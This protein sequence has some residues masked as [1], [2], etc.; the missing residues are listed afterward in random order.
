MKTR[1]ISLQSRIF[2]L[3]IV[4]VF[5][6]V[7]VKTYLENRYFKNYILNSGAEKV[8]YVAKLTAN[9]S[10]IIE[11]FELSDPSTIIQP[12]AEK[13]REITNTSF[14]VVMNMDSIRYSHPNIKNIGRY[15]VGGDEGKAKSGETYVSQARGTLGISQ[16]AFVPIYNKKNIQIGIVSVGLLITALEE[17]NILIKKILLI[18]ALISI[19]I[20]LLGGIFLANNIKKNIFGLEPYQI[21]TLLEERDAIIS[22]IKEGIIAVDKDCRI[23]LINNNA[24]VLIGVD[25]VPP[26]SIITDIFPE[27]KLPFVIKSKKEILQNSRFINGNHLLVNNIPMI[28]K[29]K[30]IGAVSS[31][32][33]ISEVLNLT[34]ELKETRAYTDALRA[35][36]HEYLNRLNVMSGLLQLKKYREATD[37]IVSTVSDQQNISD[38]LRK[39]IKTPSI[40]G[41]LIAKINRANEQHIKLTIN[42]DSYLPKI[43]KKYSEMLV[44]II[45]NI[46]ENSIESLNRA[47]RENKEI[48]IIFIDSENSIEIRI[49]DNGEGIP[50][51]YKEK[52]FEYGFSLKGTSGGRGI[53]LFIVKEQ[54]ELLNGKIEVDIGREVEFVI[55][56]QKKYII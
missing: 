45:G 20:G 34:A 5:L 39:K 50:P 3:I 36:H 14:V 56:I 8:L 49:S 33:D 28:H 23:I 40:S 26:E 54:L 44:S 6:S 12:L 31:L 53:G 41:L 17:K 42:P 1:I 35:Q 52:I 27:S 18:T 19:I 43:R 47:D 55:R 11:A 16:R 9:D 51:E 48:R 21:A 24:K 25:D 29:E 37:F 2:L 30:V 13:I 4:I 32:I 46:I 10:R 7:G 38:L 15:F 22:S